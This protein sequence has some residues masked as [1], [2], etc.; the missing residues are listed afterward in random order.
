M[1]KWIAAMMLL[2]L[3]LFGS[4]IGF[5]LFKKQKIAEFMANRPIPKLPVEVVEVQ[6]REW[7]PHI[8]AIGLIEPSQGVTL[9]TS[10]SG[11][12]SAIHFTSGQKVKRGQLLVE[13]D[14]AVEQANLVAAESR[15]PAVKSSFERNQ[16]LYQRRSVSKKTLDD[17]QAEYHALM[18]EIESLRA[19]I[20]RR[21]ISAPFDGVTGLREVHLGVY[22]QPGDEITR[23]QSLKS[24]LIRFIVPQKNLSQLTIGMEV[25]IHT[26][27][28]PEHPFDGQISAIDSAVSRDSGVLHVQ[29]KIPNSDELLRAGMY[30][31]VEIMQPQIAEALVIPTRSI[32]FS[33]YGE[34]VYVLVEKGQ[35][36]QRVLSVE[37]R[38][39]DVAERQGPWSR[40]ASG[41][42]AD[43]QVVTS[44]QVRLRN[45]AHV[46]LVDDGVIPAE[47]QPSAA[48]EQTAAN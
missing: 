44:G 24:M 34:Q 30:S 9:S 11:L 46:K 16:Q 19:V 43:E 4:V 42:S 14:S 17:A 21:Q 8:D 2:A 22:L 37:Q 3:V 32:H 15:L 1:K 39:I 7:Q 35:G 23:L 25:K 12:V 6:M 20:A 38:S 5:D 47:Q 27:A 40:I 10:V 29:A 31:S 33:L 36:E 18:A 28:Y 26:D 41:L 48:A 45:G 13:L